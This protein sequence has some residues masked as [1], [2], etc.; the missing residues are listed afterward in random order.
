MPIT[1]LCLA[2]F[3]AIYSMDFCFA[4]KSWNFSHKKN[5]FRFYFIAC[6][7]VDAPVKKPTDRQRWLT[8]EH[9]AWPSIFVRY[10]WFR[11]SL[12]PF[13]ILPILFCYLFFLMCTSRR[14]EHWHTGQNSHMFAVSFPY[15]FSTFFWYVDEKLML[16]TLASL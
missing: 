5:E 2:T 11:S 9:L 1:I 12:L 14:N 6:H 4:L 13:D 15:S 8:A 7:L 10:Y 16:H 3:G